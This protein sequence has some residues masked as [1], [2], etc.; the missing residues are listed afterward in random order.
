MKK[1][2]GL[3]LVLLATVILV[4]CGGDEEVEEKSETQVVAKVNGKEITIHELNQTLSKLGRPATPEEQEALKNKALE[5][6]IEQTL[7]VQ[8]AEEIKLDRTPEIRSALEEAKNRVLVE[9]YVKRILKGIG[10]PSKEEVDEFYNSRPEIFSERKL[11]IYKQLTIPAEKEQ[12]DSIVAQI[13]SAG[14]VEALIPLLKES[15]TTYKEAMEANTSEKLPAPLLQPLHT[16]KIGDVGFLK[17]SDGLIV[18][19]VLQSVNQPV[20]LEEAKLSIERQLLMQKQKNASL[21]V[22]ESLKTPAQI[23]YL[24]EFAPKDPKE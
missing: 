23:E 8:A 15:G 9:G 4:G 18:V 20:S 11:F 16:L 1:I 22:V 21:K 13:E 17:V 7:V 24:G 14:S 12:V 2:S 5:R 10:M 19:E 3:G 6:L